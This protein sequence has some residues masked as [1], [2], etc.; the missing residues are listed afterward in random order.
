MCKSKTSQRK[1]VHKET[2]TTAKAHKA[3][4]YTATFFSYCVYLGGLALKQA[5]FYYV[6]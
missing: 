2:W 4:G 5:L 1:A 6:H 3:D